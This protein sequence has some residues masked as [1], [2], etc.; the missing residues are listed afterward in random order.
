MRAHLPDNGLLLTICFKREHDLF[1]RGF[2]ARRVSCR[3]LRRYAVRHSRCVTHRDV[4]V[5]LAASACAELHGTQL[6]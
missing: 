5:T 6:L 1:A 3:L 4:Y 2:C